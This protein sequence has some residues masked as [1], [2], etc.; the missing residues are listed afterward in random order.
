MYRLYG[1]DVHIDVYS[2]RDNRRQKCVEFPDILWTFRIWE[3]HIVAL[4]ENSTLP[5]IYHWLLVEIS[6]FPRGKESQADS[7]PNAIYRK[8]KY[9][10]LCNVSGFQS[11]VLN[12]D[13]VRVLKFL[14]KIGRL[15]APEL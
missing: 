3:V 1:W 4:S 11:G 9:T 2:P 6:S 15:T 12:D 13:P 8:K 5:P 14:R 10:P 7:L